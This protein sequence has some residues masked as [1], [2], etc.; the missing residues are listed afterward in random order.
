[1]D[2]D[3]ATDIAEAAAALRAALPS[4]PRAAVVLGS[5]LSGLEDAIEDPVVV[6]FED[7]PGLPSVG[8]AGHGG[9][10]VHGRVGRVP[11][12]LQAGRY[13]AYE[14]HPL[15]VVVAPARILARL[16]VA[17]LIVTNASG[18]IRPLLEPGD[19]VLLDDHINLA[20]RGPLA[21]PIVG[22][23]ARFP[24]MSTPFD[25][26][27]VDTVRASASD[28]GIPLHRGVYAWVPGPSYETAAEIR[29]LAMLGADIVGM[30][31]VPEVI[32]AAAMGLR[33]VAVSLVTNRAAGL[34]PHP[35]SHDDVLEVGAR[36]ASRMRR[37]VIEVV[38][39]LH[40]ADGGGDLQRSVAAK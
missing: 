9:R 2:D 8:V 30:S 5:G 32:A 29:M 18:G 39:R 36:A 27:L 24:D 26:H 16:G 19:L 11:L 17:D 1:M 22:G 35:L 15:D 25:P 28:L 40:G 4:V 20:F 23:E 12:L 6:A 7:V 3:R 31:T 34:A 13:H 10:F 14:G 21:G 33:C 37:L 38:G